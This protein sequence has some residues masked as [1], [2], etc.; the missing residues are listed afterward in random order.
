MARIIGGIGSSHVPTIGMAC[1][2]GKHEDPDW[3]PLFEAYA[4]VARWLD[5]QQP[6]V[7][8]LFYNDHATTFLFDHYPSFALGVGERFQIAD[9]GQGPRA[10]PP[11]PS[12]PGLARH[13]AQSLVN[14][15]FDLSVFQD[16]PVDHGC[17]S[18]LTMLAPPRD[19]R[20]PVALIPFAINVLQQPVPTAL[21]C[22]KLGQALRRAVESYPEDLKVVV[23]GTGGLSHQL[24]GARAGYNNVGWDQRFLDLIA[25]D[26]QYLTRLTH[27]DFARLGGTEG[28]EVIMWLAM[29][30][31][32]SARAK[33]LH[34][35]YYL[36]MTTAM[37]VMLF[38]E[39]VAA[40]PPPQTA[41]NAQLAGFDRLEGSVL[42]DL[43]RS[44]RGLRLNRFL[45]GLADAD[46]RR[47][48]AADAEQAMADAGLADDERALLRARD[49]RGLVERGA[50]FFTLEKLA[51]VSK[52]SNPEVIAAMR[53][54]SLDTFLRTRQVPG[55][56]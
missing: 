46:R 17:N 10:L 45:H 56:R 39:P 2:Q 43:E 48:F 5:A 27:T 9:E 31:A 12:H 49:W 42:F 7:L 30:G 15:E 41:V 50:S 34:S 11:L 4:P 14:D 20:W 25:N 3:A 21:R 35:G 28:G 44:A 38:E 24:T 29:R 55:A 8:L 13:I 36:P 22:W 19:G 18:P 23:V 52:T 37:A 33:K 40:L 53:G 51:R 54:E 32:L 26:P 47:R 6:D 16:L 1:D